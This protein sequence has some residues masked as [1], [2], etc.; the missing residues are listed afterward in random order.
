M[1]RLNL[2]QREAMRMKFGLGVFLKMLKGLKCRYLDTFQRKRR[3]VAKKRKSS[4]G[5]KS[6][7]GRKKKPSA[8]ARSVRRKS[9][10]RRKRKE[11]C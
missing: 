6:W 4:E 7:S 10:C 3:N 11:S 8:G 5:W 9:C 2:V 1:W